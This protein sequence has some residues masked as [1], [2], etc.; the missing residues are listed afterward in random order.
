M[1]ITRVGGKISQDIFTPGGQA[2]QGE[3][4]NCYTHLCIYLIIPV[5]PHVR[6][7]VCAPPCALPPVCVC[8][9]A[10]CLSH[11]WHNGINAGVVEFERQ[12]KV[13]LTDLP[14]YLLEEHFLLA[15]LSRRLM[16]ELIVYQSLR[17]PSSVRQYFQTSSLLK[18]QGQFNSIFYMETP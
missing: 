8:V 2:L 18:P 12:D 13:L 5:Y 7:R 1:K 14:P 17:R 10:P 9:C 4:I 6:A 11:L 15:H 16:G 3:T